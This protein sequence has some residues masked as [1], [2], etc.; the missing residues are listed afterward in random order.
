MEG[1]KLGIESM[2]WN[3]RK[4]KE[5]KKKKKSKDRLRNLWDIFKGTNI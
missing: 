3:I 1:M 5:R 2:I 4:K